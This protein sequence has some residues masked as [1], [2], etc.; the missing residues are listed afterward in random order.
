MVQL[1]TLQGEF[2]SIQRDRQ[3]DN[4][5]LAVVQEANKNGTAMFVPCKTEDDYKKMESL[6]RGAAKVHKL[7]ADIRR[8]KQGNQEGLAWRVRPAKVRGPLSPEA[9]ATRRAK[10]EARKRQGGSKKAS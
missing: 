1:S 9:L 3:S 6:I 7:G 10:A 8:H 5:F 2:P 4:P